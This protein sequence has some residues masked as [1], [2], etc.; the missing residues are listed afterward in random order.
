MI[1]YNYG[2][3]IIVSA[4]ISYFLLVFYRLD[5]LF[6]VLTE[7]FNEIGEFLLRHITYFPYFLWENE[8]V[9]SLTY[10]CEILIE[11]RS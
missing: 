6:V 8:F 1:H 5:Y 4:D 7:Y 3:G 2:F 11:D 10:F 9:T